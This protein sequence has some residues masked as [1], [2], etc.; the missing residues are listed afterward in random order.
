MTEQ[1]KFKAWCARKRGEV[2]W[3]GLTTGRAFED[4]RERMKAVTLFA[5][6]EQRS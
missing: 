5:A 1:Q 2:N 4:L 3:L 6:P